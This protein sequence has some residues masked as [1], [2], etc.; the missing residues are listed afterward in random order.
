MLLGFRVY[1]Q[2]KGSAPMASLV[3]V[4]NGTVHMGRTEDCIS[5]RGIAGLCRAG[6]GEVKRRMVG[7]YPIAGGRCSN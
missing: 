5:C 1:L 4:R 7:V 6:V 2:P 3:F